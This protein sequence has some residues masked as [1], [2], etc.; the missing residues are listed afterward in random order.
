MN[1]S[2]LTVTKFFLSFCG[3]ARQ[4]GILPVP[5]VAQKMFKRSFH[6]LA[7]PVRLIREI[8]LVVRP[9]DSV[10]VVEGLLSAKP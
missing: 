2:A 3:A 4:K 1:I 7:V 10:E 5:N 6:H 8:H 9:Q